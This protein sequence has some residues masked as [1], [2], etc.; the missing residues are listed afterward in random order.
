MTDPNGKNVK[1]WV[2]CR[3]LP[4]LVMVEYG[5]VST[6]AKRWVSD[7][8]L[9]NQSLLKVRSSPLWKHKGFS[10]TGYSSTV[11]VKLHRLRFE[12]SQVV[13]DVIEKHNI[14]PMA[15]IGMELLPG[16]FLYPR[17]RSKTKTA[18]KEST[19]SLSNTNSQ[20]SYNSIRAKLEDDPRKSD[21][22]ADMRSL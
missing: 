5:S 8:G 9:A 3:R 21:L 4:N 20:K 19:T 2:I 18:T 22:S 1:D 6:I 12:T 14:S 13:G 15:R 16:F 17:L 11:N 7:E 10:Y